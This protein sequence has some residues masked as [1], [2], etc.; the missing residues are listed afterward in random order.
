MILLDC[1][2]HNKRNRSSFIDERTSGTPKIKGRFIL[3]FYFSRRDL[4]PSVKKT[5]LWTVFSEER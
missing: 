3:S 4:K 2:H 5:V 1:T